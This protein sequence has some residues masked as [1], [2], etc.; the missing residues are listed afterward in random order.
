MGSGDSYEAALERYMDIREYE[1]QI[2]RR[3]SSE[4]CLIPIPTDAPS[5]PED[6]R[7]LNE[8]RYRNALLYFTL[9][10]Y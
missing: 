4:G 5:C 9:R 2:R 8:A 10:R 7:I 1:D 6:G 3:I